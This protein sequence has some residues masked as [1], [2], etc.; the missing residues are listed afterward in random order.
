MGS[1]QFEKKKSPGRPILTVNAA[2]VQ[3]VRL[4]IEEDCCLSC[5]DIEEVQTK[6]PKTCVCDTGKNFHN[7]KKDKISLKEMNFQMDNARLHTAAPTQLFLASRNV[8]LVKQSPYLPYLNLFDR[9]L[10]RQVE[11]DLRGKIIAAQMTWKRLYSAVF[12]LSP[13]IACWVS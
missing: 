9:F 3:R 2:N 1:F 4:L 5:R 6:I 8:N 10:F 12:D 13:K 11:S 7:L